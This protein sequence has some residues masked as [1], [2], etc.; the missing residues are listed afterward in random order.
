MRQF[1]RNHALLSTGF[2][3]SLAVTLVFLVRLIVSTVV[4]SDPDLIRQPIAGWMTPRYVAKSWQVPPDTVATALGLDKDRTGR[5]LTLEEIAAAQGRSL[6]AL[7][8]TLEAAL[9]AS[10][11]DTDD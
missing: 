4:W 6:D 3:V 2:A 1:I 7:R 5:R 8:L 11:D 10:R 9:Q